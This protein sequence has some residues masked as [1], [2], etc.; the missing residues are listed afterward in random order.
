MDNKIE[1]EIAE[2][3]YPFRIDK[4]EDEKY[5]RRAGILVEDFLLLYKQRFIDKD[6]QDALA[7]A[8][9]KFAVK[10]IKLELEANEGHVDDKIDWIRR[11]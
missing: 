1:I 9:M 11:I 2:R 4:A 8:A 5:L 7:M 3:L 10:I 6:I